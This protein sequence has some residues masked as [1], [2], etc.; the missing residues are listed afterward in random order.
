MAQSR[1]WVRIGVVTSPV[2]LL[3]FMPET[4]MWAYP[5]ASVQPKTE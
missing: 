3:L 4:P 2:S 5:C 1:I